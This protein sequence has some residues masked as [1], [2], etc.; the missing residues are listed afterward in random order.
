MRRGL[1]VALMMVF[2]FSMVACGGAEK[3]Q[4]FSKAP[5]WYDAPMKGCGVGSAKLRSVRDLARQSAVSSARADLSRGLSTQVD[6]ML[7]RYMAE[8]EAEGQD[9]SEELTK[10]VVRDVTSQTL[11]GTRVAVTQVMNNEFYAMVCLD[12][13]TF[14]DAFSRM[15]KLS[16]KAREALNKRAKAEFDDMDEQIKKLNEQK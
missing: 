12:P 16:Q 8:G 15:D 11:V 7:K 1:L 4:D 14:A 6:A 9:F 13:E 2:S 10:S 5:D 3:K